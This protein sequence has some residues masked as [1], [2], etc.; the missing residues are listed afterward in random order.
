MIDIVE[1]LRLAGPNALEEAADEIERL[2]AEIAE[3]K[4]AAGV[5][6]MKDGQSFSIRALDLSTRTLNGLLNAGI[7]TISQ[8]IARSD[9]ELLR[10]PAVGRIAIHEV[11][12]KLAEYGLRLR[13]HHGETVNRKLQTFRESL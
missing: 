5:P 13:D 9:I 10:L 3:W 2:R 4:R 6:D 1:R 11:K 12:T 8:L 7:D